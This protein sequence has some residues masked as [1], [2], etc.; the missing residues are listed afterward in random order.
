MTASRKFEVALVVAFLSFVGYQVAIE[1]SERWAVRSL[2]SK[3]RAELKVGD[4]EEKVRRVFREN[5]LEVWYDEANHRYQS[6]EF[7]RH[8][9]AWTRVRA[10]YVHVDPEK[11]VSQIEIKLLIVI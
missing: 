3:L 10:V 8:F 11:K 1:T 6:S 4:N 2:Q 9:L 7:H 5:N